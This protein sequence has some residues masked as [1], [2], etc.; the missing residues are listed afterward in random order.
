[1]KN[2]RAYNLRKVIFRRIYYFKSRS[3]K[4]RIRKKFFENEIRRCFGT[5]YIELS[6][7][8]KLKIIP[9][10]VVSVGNICTLKCKECSQLEPYKKEKNFH[11][12]D[13]ILNWI[14]IFLAT[15]DSCGCI[16][17]IGG[18][19]FLYK[20]L[21]ELVQFLINSPK[22]NKI[23]ITT[24]GTVDIN[25]DLLTVL[26][27]DRN[28]KVIIKISD[29]KELSAKKQSIISKC[30]EKSIEYQVM[31]MDVWYRF[32]NEK[33]IENRKEKSKISADYQYF[34]CNDSIACKTIKN[35]K[36]YLCGRACGLEECGFNLL[37]GE[38][39]I[40]LRKGSLTYEELKNFWCNGETTNICRA[41]GEYCTDNMKIIVAA[42][43]L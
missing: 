10:V 20:K 6:E 31:N 28:R 14:D 25:E 29:Y 2:R 27:S 1:M 26:S 39:Y 24:N 15:I 36:L 40:D 11:D 37:E 4:N 35:G 32:G 19:P 12:L 9:R 3:K 42:E 8:N 5:N 41:C 30:K 43:Q 22:I 18:E 33:V 34:W 23:E 17:I 21:T 13:S 38:D 16:D 7:N